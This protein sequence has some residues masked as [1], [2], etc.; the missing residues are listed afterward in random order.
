MWKNLNQNDKINID[1]FNKHYTCR[2]K[3][4]FIFSS[5]KLLLIWFSKKGTN[6]S[7]QS[8]QY[9]RFV[10]F[11]YLLII[12][13]SLLFITIKGGGITNS[14][15]MIFGDV[16]FTQLTAISPVILKV[17]ISFFPVTANFQEIERGLHIHEFGISTINAEPTISKIMI[18]FF[19]TNCLY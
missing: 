18:Y 9:Y 17:N 3:F 1:H 6:F 15:I 16:R 2:C 13:I 10:W 14:S 11:S 8:C 5:L 19:K 12:E 7:Y 4:Y